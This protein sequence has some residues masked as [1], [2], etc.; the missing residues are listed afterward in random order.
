MWVGMMIQFVEALRN[1]A[2]GKRSPDCKYGL[3]FLETWNGMDAHKEKG[4]KLKT[5]K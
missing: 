5:S 3:S 4:K 1:V 2:K